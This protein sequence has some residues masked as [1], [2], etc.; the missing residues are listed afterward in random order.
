MKRLALLALVATLLSVGPGCGVYSPYGAMTSGATTFSVAAF[1]P[2]TPLASATASLILTEALRDRIQRQTTLKLVPEGG[3]LRFAADIVEWTLAPIN[4]QGNET[5]AANRLT[6]RVAVRYENGRDV[7]QD[8][9]RAFSRFVDI[10]S[11][12]DF[13]SV[14]EQVLADLAEQLS[15]D[16]FNASLGNW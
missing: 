15:Q 9:E 7:S 10:P 2:V 6:I 13:A 1:E 3:E 16:I 4:A 12:Q 8:F 11:D 14:E 5:A